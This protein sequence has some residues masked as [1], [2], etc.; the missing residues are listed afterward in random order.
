M[1]YMY[2]YRFYLVHLNLLWN[3]LKKFPKLFALTS[4][5]EAHLHQ[6][7]SFNINNTLNCFIKYKYNILTF[8]IKEIKIAILSYLSQNTLL[9]A[10]LKSIIDSLKLITRCLMSFDILISF[11]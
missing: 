11:S 9:L 7:I 6:T 8:R 2:T 1:L 3:V 5:L 4:L 10:S